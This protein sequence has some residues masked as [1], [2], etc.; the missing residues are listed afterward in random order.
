MDHLPTPHPQIGVSPFRPFAASLGRRISVSPYRWLV[1]AALSVTAL[2]CSVGPNYHRPSA[3]VPVVYKEYKGWK[4]AIPN[5]AIN[6]GAWWSIYRDPTLDALE[7]Q[8]NISNQNIKQAE[9]AYAEARAMVHEQQSS[10]FPSLSVIPQA[11]RQKS[12]GSGSGGFN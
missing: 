10:F 6:R 11:Q 8:V 5:D 3:A 2:S 12:G 9:A 1:L 4:V 7:N